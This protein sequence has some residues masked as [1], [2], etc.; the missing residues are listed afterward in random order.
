MK[1]NEILSCD[2][3]GIYVQGKQS[4]PHIT[5]NQFSFCKCAAITTNLE[6]NAYI[7]GNMI[8]RNDVGIE[9][10]N[11]RSQLIQN[12]I[13]HSVE[14]GIKVIGSH[15]DCVPLIWKNLID[16]C[17]YNGIICRG[18]KCSPDIRSNIIQLNRKAGIKI[19][20]FAKAEIRGI[21]KEADDIQNAFD[22]AEEFREK[23]DKIRSMGSEIK[24]TNYNED[25][26]KAGIPDSEDKLDGP[27]P[28]GK[29]DE[30]AE[31]N[32]I[33]WNNS[34]G[35]LIVEGSSATLVGNK[36]DSNAKANV[37]FGGALSGNTVIKK[38]LIQESQ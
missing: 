29:K 18:E 14:N 20:E 7:A 9:I 22:D 3:N 19:T 24:K 10:N 12:N 25:D 28:Y 38:N 1:R 8:D 26:Q 35:V 16:S 11:N 37:A 32:V 17:S 5:F 13:K 31:P 36:I 21:K 27:V 6:V 30:F 15:R 34:Q 2:T 33:R 23:L 4:Q